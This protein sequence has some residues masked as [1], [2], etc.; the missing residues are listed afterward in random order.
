[1]AKPDWE[2]ITERL[3]DDPEFGSGLKQH[4]EAELIEAKVT[5]NEMYAQYLN[6]LS[7]IGVFAV[8]GTV[9]IPKYTKAFGD[10]LL[11]PDQWHPEITGTEEVNTADEWPYN[12]GKVAFCVRH[13]H[14]QQDG[15][16]VMGAE[17]Y[18]EEAYPRIIYPNDLERFELFRISRIDVIE[19]RDQRFVAGILRFLTEE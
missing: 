15:T 10:W 13:A 4:I 3:R 17:A 12:R 5:G 1:M 7:G 14:I 19:H 6:S 18:T 16:V 9:Y 8:K 2:E 11:L